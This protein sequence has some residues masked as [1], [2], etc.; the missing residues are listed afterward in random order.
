MFS[1]VP[2]L[3]RTGK[4]DVFVE[5][6]LV[7]VGVLEVDVVVVEDDRDE[8]GDIYD[9][10][11]T[12]AAERG[13]GFSDDCD[14]IP[15]E[16]CESNK[17]FSSDKSIIEDDEGFLFFEELSIVVAVVVATAVAVDDDEVVLL[18]D[19]TTLLSSDFTLNL[20]LSYQQEEEY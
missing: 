12:I 1:F 14:V 13:E 4:E 7:V 10:K 20:F 15:D 18:F 9:D 17:L 3:R 8:D 5:L 11:D 2:F 6:L 19:S 16:A